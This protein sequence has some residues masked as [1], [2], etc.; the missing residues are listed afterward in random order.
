MTK[1]VVVGAG[2]QLA[3][4]LSPRLNGEVMNLERSEFDLTRTESMRDKLADLRP[5]VVFNC[6]A[7]NF[8]DRAETEPDAAFA[9]N[10][11]G[12]WALAK[13]CRDLDCML[14]H[15][16]TDYVFGLETE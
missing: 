15:F 13:V 10:T 12:V 9:V 4:D 5:D 14:V 8:V 2:G 11:W 7:Y 1:Y 16:S 6:A 3:R